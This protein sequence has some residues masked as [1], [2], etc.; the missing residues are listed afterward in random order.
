MVTYW[1]EANAPCRRLVN[2]YNMLHRFIRALL[3]DPV[4]FQR[5][6]QLQEPPP[7]E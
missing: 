7:A 3:P 6:A 1:E 2:M 4:L 5:L